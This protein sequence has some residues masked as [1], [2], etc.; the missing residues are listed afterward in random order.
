MSPASA[1]HLRKFIKLIHKNN[2]LGLCGPQN[3]IQVDLKFS[4]NDEILS[5]FADFL[6]RFSYIRIKNFCSRAMAKQTIIGRENEKELLGRIYRSRKSEFVAI[7]GRRRVGKSYLVSEFFREKIL[8]S[9]VGTYIKDDDKDYESYRKLQLSHF[10]DSLILAGLDQKKPAPTNWREAFLLLRVLL[11]GKKNRRKVLFIDE[12]PWLAG[13]QSSELI[14]ELGYFWN[15]WADSQRNIVLIVCGS[16][17]SWMLDNVIRD[18]GGLHGRLTEKIKLLPFTLA[19]CEQFYKSE[20]FHM[21]RYEIALSYMAFGGVPFYMGKLRNDLSLTDNIDRLF[22][23]DV[24]IHQ[25][26]KDVYA[27]LYSSREKYVEIVKALGSRFYGMTQTEMI[28]ATGLKSGGTFSKLLD[29]LYESGIIRKYPRYGKDRVETVYQL[30]DYFS[31]FYLRFID[32]IQ[33]KSGMWHTI[34]RTGKFYS[35]AGETFELLCVSHLNQLKEALHIYSVDNS[36]C[37]SGKTQDGAGAQIDL[38]LVNDASR[39]D[40]LCEMKFSESIFSINSEYNQ[41]IRKKIMAFSE[42]PQHN[43]THSIQVA[44]VASFG[45]STGANSDVVNHTVTLDSLFK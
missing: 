29:N 26:F 34:N 4:E 41:N 45:I 38:I 12:L 25:E 19:E 36:F 37:W 39:T 1:N 7:Y 3:L 20:G 44:I 28:D 2:I 27:G 13:P 42:S 32:G 16:A 5:N 23:A 17:T 33:N 10:Y 35:W 21:S 18:Y 24:N 11:S 22:F 14:S 6:G 15:S 31:L 8:F 40:Y 9:A 43:R 30:T